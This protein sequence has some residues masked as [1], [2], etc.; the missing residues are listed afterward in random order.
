M[1]G[2]GTGRG[3]LIDAD[4][5]FDDYGL[6]YF[7]AKR[8]K[9]LLRESAIEV[10]EMLEQ[11]GLKQFTD[12]NIEN[13]FGSPTCMPS[14][15][16]HNLYP[17]DYEECK[18]YL[19][20]IYSSFNDF[21]NRE[22]IINSLT[23]ITQQT[24]INEE[25]VAKKGSLRTNRVLRNNFTFQ[26]EIEIL[27]TEWREEIEMIL[28]L[29]CLNLK[30][31]GTSRNRGWG[32]ISCSLISDEGKDLKEKAIKNLTTG[33]ITKRIFAEV[34]QVKSSRID[35]V[36][37]PTEKSS[38]ICK[39]KYHFTNTAPLVFTSSQGDN[40]MVTSLDYIP[41]SALNGFFAH[42]F[43]KIN[44][45]DPSH[46][47]EDEKFREWFLNCGLIF[48]NAYLKYEFEEAC[49][50]LYP[51]P[52]FLHTNK[53][54]E[55]IYN[56]ILEKNV[57]D[58]ETIG[59]Y[60]NYFGNKLIINRNVE[61]RI[62]FHLT[63]NPE[64]N[65]AKAR[66][67]GHGEDGNI[68]HYQA[69]KEGQ[70][71]HGY[72]LGSYENLQAFRKM[73]AADLSVEVYLG[74]SINTQYG[75]AIIKFEEPEEFKVED[76]FL[77]DFEDVEEYSLLEEGKQN[78]VVLYFLSPVILYNS[79]GYPEISEE[80]LI[81]HLARRINISASDIKIVKSFARVETYQGFVSHWKTYE[82]VYRGYGSGSSFLLEFTKEIDEEKLYLIMQKGL[83]EKCH[84]G[85]GQV[86]FLQAMPTMSAFY[87]S[88]RKEYYEKPAQMPS[89]VE[90]I[91]NYIYQE[92]LERIVIA[93]ATYRAQNCTGEI[94][95]SLLGKLEK[96]TSTSN[97]TKELASAIH[98]L[99]TKAQEPLKNIKVENNSL[100]A[101][102][103]EANLEQWCLNI[104]HLNESYTKSGRIGKLISRSIDKDLKLYRYH[105]LY[106]RVFLRTLRK[107]IQK[108]NEGGGARC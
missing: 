72:I 55:E 93:T 17:E 25:G 23:Y 64:T 105:K 34:E 76:I 96:V 80:I 67:E 4:I 31:A 60:S 103:V 62:N 81:E 28:A 92:E 48:S 27:S 46:A 61:K 15:R 39:M 97:S 87:N 90:D 59:G 78:Q 82:P 52:L 65:K 26:G 77:T 12:L 85:Y 86:V 2:S 70:N 100:Y 84:L 57:D 10:L 74:R 1:L 49:Y 68:F 56:L 75:K 73:F 91:L 53:D 40:N 71:F 69:I 95:P 38:D 63:R 66:V 29:A 11:A 22:K 6:P 16:V 42:E 101:N 51:T 106:W 83:G 43:I 47:H 7:P 54:R 21:I 32:E 94:S 24:A 20:Y 19:R 102:L 50:C 104:N 14:I 89:L 58:S 9:G 88:D 108:L 36:S 18:K 33:K 8:L 79:F 98:N 99:R 45:L 35:P 30:R 37:L 44:N 41:G 3:S 5:V 107:R 13:I